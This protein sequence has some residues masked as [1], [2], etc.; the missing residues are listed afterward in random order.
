[1]SKSITAFAPATVANVACG[2]DIIGF[3]LTEPGD[4]VTASLSSTPGVCIEKIEGGDGSMPMDPAKNTAGVA[5]DFLLQRIDQ[6]LGVTLTLKKKMPIGSGLGSSASSAVAAAVATN[7]LLDEPLSREELL[8]AVIEAERIACGAPHADNVAPSLLGGFVLIRSYNPL[9]IVC[10]PS[11]KNLF[12]V[13]VHPNIEVKTED[14]RKV[15]QNSIK[16]DEAVKQWANVGG[17]IAG[18]YRS[19]YDLIGRSLEDVIAEPMRSI[20]IPGFDEVKQAALG[21]GALGFSISGSGPSVFAFSTSDSESRLIAT[22]M[23]AEFIKVGLESEAY[24]SRINPEG[25]RIL[26]N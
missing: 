11:P 26:N 10:I 2:F 16:L 25:A 8:P 4:E 19:D 22:T 13:V 21:A 17:L 3:A 23:Q 9:D 20:L 1:M 6:D 15:L 24:I 5:V 12:A 7:E 18:L 14:A